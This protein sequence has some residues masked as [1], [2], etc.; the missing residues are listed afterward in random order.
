MT[1]ATFAKIY[2]NNTVTLTDKRNACGRHCCSNGK[3]IF[4][5]VN[6]SK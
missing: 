3:P 4:A 6:V 5:E 1:V 2:K